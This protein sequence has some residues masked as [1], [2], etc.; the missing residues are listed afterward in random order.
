MG[1]S[2]GCSMPVYQQLP[3]WSSND[4]HDQKHNYK[5]KKRL[6]IILLKKDKNWKEGCWWLSNK[7][8]L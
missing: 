6:V 1:E 3:S 7:N 2:W 4:K 5:R 8:T